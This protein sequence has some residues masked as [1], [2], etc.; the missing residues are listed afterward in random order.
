VSPQR[1]C[2]I[3]GGIEG[4]RLSLGH[5]F[6]CEGVCVHARS[7]GMGCD[8]YSRSTALHDR[9]SLSWILAHFILWIR[10]HVETHHGPNEYR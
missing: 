1:G 6:S 10:R 9:P 4:E 2:L 8:V 7:M 5:F 3:G